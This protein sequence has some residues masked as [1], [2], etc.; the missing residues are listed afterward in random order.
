M[1]TVDQRAA[2][3]ALGGIPQD[4]AYVPSPQQHPTFYELIELGLA[5]SRGPGLGGE[6]FAPTAQGRTVYEVIKPKLKGFAALS[7][8]RRRAI[9]RKGGRSVEPQE[10][11]FSKNRL[12]ASEAGRKG[13]EASEGGRKAR[14][15][16][17]GAL[18]GRPAEPSQ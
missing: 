13:G 7:P 3:S 14:K 17:L 4:A 2:L 12:L 10:R 15:L 8:E 11:S 18:K 6:G 9:A 16:S 1:L 5:V